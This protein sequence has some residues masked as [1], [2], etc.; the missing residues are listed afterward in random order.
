MPSFWIHENALDILF[1]S[2]SQQTTNVLLELIITQAVDVG[3]NKGIQGTQQEHQVDLEIWVVIQTQ[4]EEEVETTGIHV[5]HHINTQEDH[6][7]LLDVHLSL[8]LLGFLVTEPGL[9][10]SDTRANSIDE[11]PVKI[12]TEKA[13]LYVKDWYVCLQMPLEKS[14]RT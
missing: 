8:T 6:T 1:L 4:H 9:V 13:S 3:V 14:L 7:G 2:K 10:Y 11:S 5:R 12:L